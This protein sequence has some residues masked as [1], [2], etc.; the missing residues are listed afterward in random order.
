MWT[1]AYTV[2]FVNMPYALSAATNTLNANNAAADKARQ[3][4]VN[5]ANQEKPSF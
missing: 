3:D 1:F 4:L 5:K 2:E